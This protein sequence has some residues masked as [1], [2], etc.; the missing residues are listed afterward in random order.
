MTLKDASVNL[1]NSLLV[2][3]VCSA[4]VVPLAAADGALGMS[5]PDQVRVLPDVRVLD[6]TAAAAAGKWIGTDGQQYDYA[7]VAVK[8]KHGWL[9]FGADFDNACS[10]G[11]PGLK[12]A[13]DQ[14]AKVANII[15]ASGRRVVWTMAPNKSAPLVRYVKKKRVP[16]G[17]CAR[18][19][20]ARQTRLLRNYRSPGYLPM[21]DP[22]A[23]S[24][25]EVYWKTDPHWSTVGGAIYAKEVARALDPKLAAIQRSR[26]GTETGV[27]SLNLLRGIDKKETLERAYPAT[28]V[29]VTQR[30]GDTPWTGY[31]EFTWDTSWDT[32][33]AKRTW[34]GKTLVIGDSFSMFGLESIRPLFRHGR[35]MW[36]AHVALQDMVQAIKQSDTVVLEVFELYV[37]NTIVGTK[38]FQ[39]ELRQALR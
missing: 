17:K 39:R 4:F 35:W 28:N 7:P 14:L 22:L 16:H 1:R 32:K 25:H 20:M 13:A 31:P 29:K 26:Y 19:G 15:R 33:P 6:R 3:I 34:P 11:G 5:Q 2:A 37:P 36:F 18:T 8:G 21:V 23:A 9:Y 10:V 12:E 30:P 38:D 24:K 27:G